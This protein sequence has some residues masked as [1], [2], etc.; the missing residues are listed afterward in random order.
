MNQQQWPVNSRRFDGK[1]AIVTGGGDAA[2]AG[3]GL[4]T[5][6]A[7]CERLAA[8]GCQ[9][10]VLDRSLDLAMCTVKRI[11]DKGGRAIA[12]AA[13]VSAEND[14]RAA[15]GQVIDNFGRIDVL[16]NNVGIESY[17]RDNKDP[18]RVHL[19]RGLLIPEI[20]VADWDQVMAVNVRGMML[21]AKHATPFLSKQ[22]PGA[23]SIVTISSLAAL[24]PVRGTAAYATSKG[25]VVTLTYSMAIDLA[26][27]RANCVSPGQV[28][29]P[30]AMRKLPKVAEKIESVRAIR[31]NNSLLRTEGTG[32]DIAQA[33]AFLASDDARWI[34]GQHLVVDGGYGLTGG[35]R[36]MVASGWANDQA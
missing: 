25:A 32:D 31:K 27:I 14:C 23:A 5:G 13:D 17:P 36:D 18:K 7:I 24:Q 19:N 11:E 16:V 2:L 28:W 35:V 26:P 29:T 15:V 3:V 10:A 1:V 12:V 21:M 34:T 6:A 33:V 9:V 8:E 4:G 22:P 30:A 20:E